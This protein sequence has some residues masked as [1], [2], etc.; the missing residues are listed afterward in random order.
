M[1]S[2]IIV[3]LI[4]IPIV[5]YTLFSGGLLLLFFVNI[6]IGFALYEYYKMAETGGEKPYKA[7]GMAFGIAIPNAVYCIM[8][9]YIP[10]NL[11]EIIGIFV[12]VT[13]GYSVFTKKISGSNKNI[14]I[15][16]L[17]VMY[18]SVLFSHML[19]ISDLPNGGKWLITLIV[20]VWICDSFAYFVGMSMG[21]KLF[22]SG[23]TEISPKKSKEGAIGGTIFTIIA[24]CLL[25][26]YFK[27]TAG[28]M[29]FFT[30]IIFGLVI[31]IVAQ[32]G[33]LGESLFKRDFK[34]KDSDNILKGHGGILDRFDS[35]LFV[36]PVA[37]YILRYLVYA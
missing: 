35:L 22:P 34:V 33:D 29:S 25:E 32:I 30:M 7:L 9:G 26:K 6:I 13:I 2:R 17:G 14:G 27:V 3:A 28:K 16:L 11:S 18:I 37:Y 1:L 4:G 15:T 5:L 10:M 24:F 21:R 12:L 36:V 8:K 23:L 19:L 31:S 20:M